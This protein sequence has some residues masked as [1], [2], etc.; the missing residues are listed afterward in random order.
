MVRMAKMILGG[1][2]VVLVAL[3]AGFLWGASGRSTITRALERSELR[4]E[5]LE[6]RG[7]ASPHG[8]ISKYEP[9]RRVVI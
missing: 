1:V 5:L 2:A 7:A 9:A 3:L 4:N 6:A 8:P